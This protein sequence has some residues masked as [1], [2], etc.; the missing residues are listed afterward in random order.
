MSGLHAR[1]TTAA[2][3]G[4]ACSRDQLPMN[5][6]VSSMLAKRP[7]ARALSVPDMRSLT[8]GQAHRTTR[9][10]FVAF[11]SHPSSTPTATR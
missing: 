6:R 3:A 10:S 2:D 8:S 5:R 9:G 1:A 7:A 11:V 4:S